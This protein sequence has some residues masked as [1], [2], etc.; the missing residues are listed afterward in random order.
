MP[1]RGRSATKVSGM[2][3]LRE[4]PPP[5]KPPRPILYWVAVIAA[6]LFAG[7]AAYSLFTLQVFEGVVLVLA[8]WG[9]VEVAIK[10]R[11]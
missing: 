8:T 11:G 9:L 1:R 4:A 10:V 2:G 7:S 5:Y 3:Y 6:G